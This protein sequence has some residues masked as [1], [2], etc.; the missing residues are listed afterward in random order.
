MTS[1]GSRDGPS[2]DLS[3]SGRSGSVADLPECR[4]QTRASFA[5]VNAGRAKAQAQA[6]ALPDHGQMTATKCQGPPNLNSTFHRTF[7]F[8][9]VKKS[10]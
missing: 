1:A 4:S 8:V 9:N 7:S 2:T 3:M 10:I 6:S 5:N